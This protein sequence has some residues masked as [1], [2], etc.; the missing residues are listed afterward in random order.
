MAYCT[1]FDI[2][3]SSTTTPCSKIIYF[4]L[5]KHMN[6]ICYQFESFNIPGRNGEAELLENKLN[7]LSTVTKIEGCWGRK[8]PFFFYRNTGLFT[9]V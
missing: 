3:L 7:V 6:D 1:V 5:F 2:F 9:N 8:E 4:S